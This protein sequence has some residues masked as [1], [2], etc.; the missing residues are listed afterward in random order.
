MSYAATLKKVRDLA[1]GKMKTAPDRRPLPPAPKKQVFKANPL[2]KLGQFFGLAVLLATLATQASQAVVT[3]YCP[4]AVCCGDWASF[5]RT[6]SGT[7]PKPGRTV[8]APRGVPF[9]SRIYIAGLGWRV[10]EDRTAR[11]Y[12][13]RFDVFVGTHREAQRLGFRRATVRIEKGQ[14]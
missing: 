12:D 6:A 5:H 3:A 4:C 1:S 10:A 2:P 9:G 14:P 11:Q 8:A 7:V 13:G